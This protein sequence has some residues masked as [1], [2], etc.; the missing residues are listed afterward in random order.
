MTYSDPLELLI[1]LTD[2]KEVAVILAKLEKMFREEEQYSAN[3]Q[4]TT[5][6]HDTIIEVQN[7]RCP[8][9]KSYNTRDTGITGWTTDNREMDVGFTTCNDCGNQFNID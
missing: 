8:L 1:Q 7:K 2:D 5:Y 9:C 6:L 3:W 4:V